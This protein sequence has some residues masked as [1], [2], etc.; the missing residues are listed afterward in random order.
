MVRFKLNLGNKRFHALPKR[1][2]PKV[3]PVV[4]L[5]FDFTY[6]EFLVQ[7]VSHYTTWAPSSYTH[8]Y[9]PK[10]SWYIQRCINSCSF[11]CTAYSTT[12]I[13]YEEFLLTQHKNLCNNFFDMSLCKEVYGMLVSIKLL[14]NGTSSGLMV[15]WLFGWTL[16]HIN[17]VGYLIANPVY[18]YVLIIYDL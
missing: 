15:G 9:I 12:F 13:S 18:T 16:W 6:Y 5:E 11:I 1:T 10:N 14:P 4:R 8:L 2:S 7:Y 3:N 17:I